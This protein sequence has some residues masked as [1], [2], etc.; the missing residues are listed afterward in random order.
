MGLHTGSPYL[1]PQVGVLLGQPGFRTPTQGAHRALFSARR[2]EAQ[3]G[4]RPHLRGFVGCLQ[5]GQQASP[6]QELGLNFLPHLLCADLGLASDRT[7]GGCVQQ[8]DTPAQGAWPPSPRREASAGV[9][10]ASHGFHA[11]TFSGGC[12]LEEAGTEGPWGPLS[13]VLSSYFNWHPSHGREGGLDSGTFPF[14]SALLWV[15]QAAQ[16]L[17]WLQE[18]T[19]GSCIV[20]RPHL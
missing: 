4:P 7:P 1:W 16:G 13:K 6:S 17:V 10:S 2:G 8:A 20:F 14:K 12:G 9:N 11:R 3:R 15:C 18:K 19:Q 5:P